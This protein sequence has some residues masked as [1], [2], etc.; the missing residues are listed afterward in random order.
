MNR[1]YFILK[2]ELNATTISPQTYALQLGLGIGI[3]GSIIVVTCIGL[4]CCNCY[5]KLFFPKILSILK[6]LIGELNL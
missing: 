2:Q 1:L 6:S 5:G 3:P 4:I